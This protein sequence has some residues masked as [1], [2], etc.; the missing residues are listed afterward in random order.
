MSKMLD[1]EAV[2]RTYGYKVVE[3][4][5]KWMEEDEKA[6]RSLANSDVDGIVSWLHYYRVFQGFTSKERN[7]VAEAIVKW[8]EFRAIE[9]DLSSAQLL[10]DAH[11]ELMRE[12]VNALGRERDLT[13]LV[14]KA[15]WLCYPQQVPIYDRFARRALTVLSHL[16]ENIEPA[17]KDFS[18][19]GKFA[20]SWKYFFETYA[21]SIKA[22]DMKSSRYPVRVLDMILWTIGVDSF[23]A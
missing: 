11:K 9:R 6:L 20:H 1:F 21:D 15:L 7:D 8:A 22:I 5:C 16:E 3:N 14:S 19:Y 4:Y 18:E 17:P 10:D 12:C 23:G 13:S 2:I